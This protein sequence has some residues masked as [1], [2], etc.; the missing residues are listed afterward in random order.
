ME[1]DTIAV[2]VILLVAPVPVPQALP[3][4]TVKVPPVAP[5]EKVMELD[6]DAVLAEKV[7]PVPE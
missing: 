3:G 6:G 4:V 7:A 5:A 2:I 1:A